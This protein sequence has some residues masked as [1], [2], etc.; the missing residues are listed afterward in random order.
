MPTVSIIMPNHNYVDFIPDAIAS[1]KAQTLKDFECIIIDDASS[2][3]SVKTIRK[4]IKKDPRFKLVELTEYG[5]VS[6]AR[7]IGLDMATGEYIAFLDSDDCYTSYALEK[8]VNIARHE[9]VDVVGGKCDFVNG[10]FHWCPSV[11]KSDPGFRVETDLNDVMFSQ[12]N[13]KW[14]WI[15][16][17]IYKR[18][19][20][21]DIRFQEEMK[22]NGEDVVFCLDFGFKLKKFIETEII[23]VLHR[24]HPFQ[25]TSFRDTINRERIGVF[26]AIFKYINEKLLDKYSYH[27]FCN[28][29][30]DLF[31][32][33]CRECLFKKNLSESD[34]EFVRKI[35]R[36]SCSMI[37]IKYLKF[38]HKILC[39]YIACQ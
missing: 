39:R 17:R 33:L 25:I 20:L 13:S 3:D 34:K 8:L 6:H 27:F 37:P 12:T 29:Y 10:D 28:L 11:D 16:R 31:L 19:L 9:N 14:I 18:S 26:P 23:T 4:L 21:Q 2:D 15:W 30:T 38:K 36:D 1:I 22:I 35:M 32:Y 7:N 24:I 5:G